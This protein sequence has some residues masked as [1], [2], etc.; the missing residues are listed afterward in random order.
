MSQSANLFLG[1]DLGTS[2]CR[3]IIIDSTRQVVAEAQVAYPQT[4]TQPQQ[5]WQATQQVLQQ[6]DQ[7]LDLQQIAAVAIDGTSGTLF[8]CDSAGEPLTPALL[9]NDNR[10]SAQAARL[11][12]VIADTTQQLGASSGLAKV[13]WLL[14]HYPPTVPY[15]VIHQADWIAGQFCRRF[16]FSDVNNVLKTGY[17]IAQQRWPDELSKVN[18]PATAF[19]RVYPPG[20]AV[21]EIDREV[22]RQYNLAA[23]TKIVAGTT[24]ST[25]AVIASGAKPGDGMTSLGSTLVVKVICD[26]PISATQF[27]VYSQPFG[28]HWLVGGASNSGGAVLRNFF[29]DTQLQ[30]LT[31]Q[32]H[33]Q[34]PSGLDYYPLLQAGERFPIN[35][36][37]YPAR[38]TPRPDSDVEFLQGLLEGIARIEKQGYDR[39]AQ[40]G[41]PY[42]QRVLTAGGGAINIAWQQ[43]RQAQLGVPVC[44]A[45]HAE[46]AY[47]SALLALHALTTLR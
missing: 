2:G 7:Q 11:Q 39:L 37:S 12:Q 1:I 9:Y 28:D 6:L 22:A 45:E 4:A 13:L 33:P 5:W 32:L 34:R 23:T 3:G 40:L 15:R 16:D 30:A 20:S 47:G 21:T 19:P 38:L 27:G 42:P 18:L 46:A 8:L 31:P 43:I 24:D 44:R 17:D 14:E 29:S 26:H 35:D 25:A 36:S 10:A 41:A